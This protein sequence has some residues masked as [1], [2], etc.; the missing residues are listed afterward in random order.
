[1]PR[2][3]DENKLSDAVRSFKAQCRPIP[4]FHPHLYFDF[5]DE[6]GWAE[7]LSEVGHQTPDT[8]L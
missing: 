8:G 5:S 7:F 1:M 6:F 4:D 2:E 3:V